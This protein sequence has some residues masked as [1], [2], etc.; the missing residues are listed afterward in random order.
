MTGLATRAAGT[1]V[2][3]ASGL[4]WIKV[5]KIAVPVIAALVAFLWLRGVL[6]ERAELRQWRDTT[7]VAVRAEMPVARRAKVT[8]NT[9]V[10][11]IQWLG[12]EYRTHAE[13][14]RI[15][16]EKLVTAKKLAGAAQNEAAT[17]RKQAKERNR[18]REATRNAILAPARSTGL[19]AAEWG[20]L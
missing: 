20:K 16:S 17:A 13:A 6:N 10:G 2:A 8:A 4:N 19:T 3:T 15:Q 7:V 9:A 11:D 14:L 18:D 5:A 1:A 12:R